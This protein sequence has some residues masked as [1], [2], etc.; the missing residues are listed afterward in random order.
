MPLRSCRS[1]TLRAAFVL[2][3]ALAGSL[4]SAAVTGPSAARA[5]AFEQDSS[6][7]A[8]AR[9]SSSASALKRVQQ[10]LLMQGARTRMASARAL[11]QLLR[12]HPEQVRHGTGVRRRGDWNEAGG[13]QGSITRT[14]GEQTASSARATAAL[15]PAD[16]LVNDRAQDGASRDIGQAEQMIAAQCSNILVAWNDGLGFASATNTSTQGYGYSVDGGVTYTDGGSPPVPAGWRWA[17]DPL[18]TVN[19]KTGDFWFCAMVDDNS[20][21]NGIALVKA[22]FNAGAVQWST[23]ALV[24]SG[25]K[26]S[27]LFDKPWLAVDS[28]SGR[29]YLA[30]TAFSATV[31][32]IVF[33]RSSAGGTT[34]DSPLR[35]SSNAEA[36]YVQGARPAV[37]PGGEVYVTWY[38]IESASPYADHMKIRK[39][40]DQG[41]TFNA[42]VTAAS[43]Y[44]NFGSGAPGFNRGTGI[45]YPSIAVDRSTGAHRGRIYMAWNESVSIWGDVYAMGTTGAVSETEPNDAPATAKTFNIGMTLRGTLPADS[46]FDFFRFNGTAG[47]TVLFYADSLTSSL[48]MSLRLFC[49]DGTT[50]LALSVPPDPGPGNFICFTLPASGTYYLRCCS[51][52]HS[53]G[54]YRIATG[55]HTPTVGERARD[56][57]D[58]F[59]AWSDDGTTWS[60]PAMASD[61][62]V[63]F[64]D[65]L[66]EVAVGGDNTDAQVGD[67][68]P[69]CLWYDWR[70][71]ASICGGGSNVYLSRSDDHGTTWTPGGTLNAAQTDWT[72]V[73]SNLMPNQGDYLSLFGNHANLYAAW[74]D[75]RNGDPDI[76]AATVPLQA[77][78]FEA[79]FSSVKSTPARVTLTWHTGGNARPP[80]S[81]ERRGDLTEFGTIGEAVNDCVGNLSFADATVSPGGRYAYRLA[82]MDGATRRTTPEVWV[83][84]PV[85]V[86]A[87]YGAQPNP[88]HSRREGVFISLALPDDTPATLELLDVAGRRLTE[89]RVAGA[90]DQRVNISEGLVLTRGIYFVRLT[91]GGR[92]LSRRVTVVP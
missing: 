36:G 19:E 41:A 72:N 31:D 61:S 32:T 9:A 27:V 42:A 20:T 46:D 47:Q 33:Q 62:P 8:S 83:D 10:R 76:Y 37:G 16:V 48:L 82:W 18:V 11:A 13:P 51:W 39:S 40:T 35:L 69:Y 6:A 63:G 17:S 80:V 56:H 55:L 12:K 52:D 54:I 28:L 1:A 66:P 15:V 3:L 85:A 73:S 70:G 87:L 81:V 50:R 5:G 78:P 21:R 79:E 65:W 90:G 57:R 64:D 74:T 84:V 53:T 7:S 30:Y 4:F 88:P 43:V 45:T 44:S 68:R 49:T 34:W 60:T 71:S 91:W 25:N 67:S 77:T 24:R 29:L 75:G 58:A 92:S 2:T 23:P 86:F 38:S 14:L 22:H 26:A 59:V 89:R